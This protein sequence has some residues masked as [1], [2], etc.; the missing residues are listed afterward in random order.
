M[1]QANL[2]QSL[3]STIANELR[4]LRLQGIIDY[5]FVSKYSLQKEHLSH[6][7]ICGAISTASRRCGY[8]PMIELGWYRP[9]SNRSHLQ[10]TPQIKKGGEFKPDLSL[11]NPEAEEKKLK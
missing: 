1:S 7:I 5:D 9:P 6:S 3:L 2:C 8:V 11:L 4:H 10:T